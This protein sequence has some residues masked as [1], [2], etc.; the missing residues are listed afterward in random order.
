MRSHLP[1]QR[2]ELCHCASDRNTV[3]S[4]GYSEPR[5]GYVRARPCLNRAPSH[6][7][8]VCSGLR[9]GKENYFT[10]LQAQRFVWSLKKFLVQSQNYFQGSWKL[11]LVLGILAQRCCLSLL[12]TQK[13]HLREAVISNVKYSNFLFWGVDLSGLREHFQNISKPS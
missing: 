12:Q 1:R 11:S 7:L 8:S 3:L 9:A 6:A 2:R 13:E 5:K 4:A 10:S